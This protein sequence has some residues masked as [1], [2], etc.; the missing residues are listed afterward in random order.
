LRRLNIPHI[1]CTHREHTITV[2]FKAV[3]QPEIGHRRRRVLLQTNRERACDTDHVKLAQRLARLGV[4][5]RVNLKRRRRCVLVQEER[6]YLTHL[7]NAL[8]EVHRA[9]TGRRSAILRP[10]RTGVRVAAAINAYRNTS[11]R[12]MTR[13]TRR[14]GAT[15]DT[16]QTLTEQLN[17]TT[18]VD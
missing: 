2:T 18:Q 17:V 1:L 12:A 4:S 7:I 9:R 13:A 5:N 10:N 6:L 11:T 3:D 14:V 15:I 16:D 8:L